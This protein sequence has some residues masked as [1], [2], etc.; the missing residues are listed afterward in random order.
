VA[1]ISSRKNANG[2]VTHTVHFRI[3]G[4]SRKE[5]FKDLIAAENFK[6]KEELLG[7][8]EAR[9]WLQRQ[10]HRTGPSVTFAEWAERY[11]DPDTGL[12]TGIEPGTRDQYRRDTINA[13]NPVLGDMPIDEIDKPA[14]GKW[15]TWQESQVAARGPH[16]GQP[17][18]AKTVKN[19]H[20][21]LSNILRAAVEN[22]LRLDNPA[23]RT[24]LS[25]GLTDEAVFLSVTD[26]NAL[27]E[28]IADR[29]KPLVAFL[30]GS[31]CRLS[32]ALALT[33]GDINRDTDPP[34]VRIMKAWKRNPDG[35]AQIGTTKSK[36]GRRTV[37]LWPALV[38]ELGKPGRAK[39][40]VFH[41]DDGTRIPARTFAGAWERAIRKSGLDQTPRIH[42]L[43][44]TGVSWLI[45]D[46]VPLPFIQQRVGHANITTTVQVYGHL[47]PDAH[48]RMADSL[49]HTLSRVVTDH[50]QIE[51]AR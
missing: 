42:D 8:K 10:A 4:Q 11:L 31:Q 34:T 40:L 23:Y 15:V 49:S 26:Y 48:T 35:P 30:V 43:R 6:A 7:G 45:A 46:G 25:A 50:K 14:I 51:D 44:H 1:S 29:W 13:L 2:S 12:L 9:A 47:L 32:E 24:R 28:A 33:W 37:A 19:R 39:D 27:Y 5:T 17:V 20:G 18:S 36:K 16:K 21:L 3:D 41:N 22:G 38:T